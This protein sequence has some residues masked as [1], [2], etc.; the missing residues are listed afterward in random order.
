M[1]AGSHMALVYLD[2]ARSSPDRA[3]RRSRPLIAVG[4]ESASAGPRSRGR[5]IADGMLGILLLLGVLPAP[6]EGHCLAISRQAKVPADMRALASAI[7][8][9][10]A[11]ARALP[12][13]LESLTL[14]TK[15]SQGTLRVVRRPGD[16][17]APQ[18]G[19]RREPG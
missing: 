2:G 7:A 8:M 6:A 9:Y 10:R 11:E 5:R 16:R 12:P 18:A 4:P 14:S 3:R 19:S 13:S 17:P 15:D 1:S